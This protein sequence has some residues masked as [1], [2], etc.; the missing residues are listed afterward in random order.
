MSSE[1]VKD[2]PHQSSEDKKAIR[3]IQ[4]IVDVCIQPKPLP[5]DVK[6]RCDLVNWIYA[7]TERYRLDKIVA[8]DAIILFDNVLN[9][10]TIS[11]DL[12][13]MCSFIVVSEN[14]LTIT[15]IQ[16]FQICHTDLHQM[17]SRVFVIQLKNTI[18]ICINLEIQLIFVSLIV[19]HLFNI[20][21][22]QCLLV[23]VSREMQ[24]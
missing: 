17:K 9:K 15:P 24:N 22:H 12:I 13:M 14:K 23:I 5:E 19:H 21:I 7:I 18:L 16:L 8:L 2:T 1:I 6:A 4:D 10:L 20:I 11:R 3:D